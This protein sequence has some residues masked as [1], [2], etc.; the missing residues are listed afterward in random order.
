VVDWR[1]ILSLDEGCSGR[2]P[3]M[4]PVNSMQASLPRCRRA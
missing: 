2:S 1:Q 3:M 4:L